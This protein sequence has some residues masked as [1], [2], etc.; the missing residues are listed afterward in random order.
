MAQHRIDAEVR[1]R[2]YVRRRHGRQSEGSLQRGGVHIRHKRYS[3]RNVRMR[4]EDRLSRVTPQKNLLSQAALLTLP[5]EL[6]L[7]IA[8]RPGP[9]GEGI[10]FNLRRVSKRMQAIR[11]KQLFPQATL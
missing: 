10:Y 2:I 4:Q 1:G 5:N 11:D 9:G 3:A 7:Q 8:G 6:L